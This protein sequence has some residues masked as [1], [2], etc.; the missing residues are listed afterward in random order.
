[1]IC[2]RTDL[3]IIIVIFLTVLVI[4][5]KKEIRISH[6]WVLAVINCGILFFCKR[7]RCG[8]RQIYGFTTF[9]VLRGFKRQR[10][11][12]KMFKR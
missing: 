10:N 8:I 9:W 1:M 7:K 5:K 3:F 4:Q 2:E 12:C 11:V 6:V